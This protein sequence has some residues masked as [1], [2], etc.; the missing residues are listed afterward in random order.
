VKRKVLFGCRAN[1][2]QAADA[3]ALGFDFFEAQV[4]SLQPGAP[5][6]VFAALR[7]SF[8]KPTCRPQVFHDLMPPHLPVLGK[9]IPYAENRRWVRRAIQ[10]AKRL[11]GKLVVLHSPSARRTPR[12]LDARHVRTQLRGFVRVL[13]E[14]AAKSRVHVAL[15]PLPRPTGNVITSL[16]EA[17]ALTEEMGID[18]LCIAL[19]VSFG[20]E[21]PESVLASR[22]GQERLRYVR[23]CLPEA[24]PDVLQR[25]AP[26]PLFR[27]LK[28]AGFTGRICLVMPGSDLLVPSRDFT[29][30]LRTEWSRA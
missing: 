3:A 19:D 22:K 27:S 20:S 6:D 9:E 29:T 28:H 1:L 16:A 11:G 26:A 18:Y 12:D 5:D 4:S 24:E 17:A 13:G 25:C 15:D 23:L 2:E 8:G 10:R 21:S 30:W 7:A 14:Y